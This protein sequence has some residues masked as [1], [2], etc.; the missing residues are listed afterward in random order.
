MDDKSAIETAKEKMRFFVV[1]AKTRLAAL[2]EFTRTISKKLAA[3][4]KTKLGPMVEDAKTKQAALTSD[5]KTKFTTI[6]GQAKT[7]HEH[8]KVRNYIAK[9]KQK[10]PLTIGVMIVVATV[11]IWFAFT[12]LSDTKP[13][14]KLLFDTVT[15]DGGNGLV[16][17]TKILARDG[18][19]DGANKYVV[20]V[21]YEITWKMDQKQALEVMMEMAYKEMKAEG[22]PEYQIKMALMFGGM[23]VALSPLV[24][25]KPFKAGDR[26][27]MT[28]VYTFVK[29]ESGWRVVND[30]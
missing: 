16:Y 25:E 11:C 17:D 9:L 14:D 7:V 21:E 27:K 1:A 23:S 12:A 30:N 8:P 24:G 15:S 28:D 19:E 22:L 18:Y 5:A 6:K 26:Q 2:A 10:D 29:A 3:R 13:S 4:A 20:E